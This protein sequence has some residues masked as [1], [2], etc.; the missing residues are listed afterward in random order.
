MNKLK[1][2]LLNGKFRAIRIPVNGV[3]I[4]ALPNGNLVYSTN[5]QV[6]LL[7]EN[8]QEV[9]NVSLG[10][11]GDSFCA[12]YHRNEIYVSD[13]SKH[14]IILFDLNLNELKKFG[15]KGVG[16][17]QLK[18][19][20]GLCCHGDY[21]YICDSYNERIQILTLDFEYVSTI[22]TDNHSPCRVQTSETTIGVSCHEA[23]LFY[24]LNTR[25]LKYKHNILRTY[26]INYID[27][28]FCAINVWENKFYF[29][30]SDGNFVEEKSFYEERMLSNSMNTGS[31]CIYKDIL[32]MTEPSGWLYQFP[33]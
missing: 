3:S 16:N 13:Y 24:D 6:I 28:I 23:T 25:A 4:N 33:E 1:R 14:C 15:T 17:N 29:F 5:N 18:G 20:C 2:V 11:G 30:D 27:S 32:Y 8:F 21:L 10:E 26:N 12:S 22:Q 9:K 31:M 7:N 19:P